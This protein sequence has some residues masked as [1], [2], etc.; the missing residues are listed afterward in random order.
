M[1]INV[2]AFVDARII[3]LVAAAP[4]CIYAAVDRSTILLCT[5]ESYLEPGVLISH[6]QGHNQRCALQS[7]FLTLFTSYAQ[8]HNEEAYIVFNSLLKFL[9]IRC[10]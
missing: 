3:L 8:A 5:Y 10:E 9:E 4:V 1:T 2:D 6:L 7:I